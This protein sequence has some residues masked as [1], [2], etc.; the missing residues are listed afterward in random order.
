M[1]GDWWQMGSAGC[2]LTVQAD[3]PLPKVLGQPHLLPPVL[4]ILSLS[5]HFRQFLAFK[6]SNFETENQ[7]GVVVKV[8]G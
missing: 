8:P 5:Y 3:T 6:V 7:F 4:F 2:L 1:L